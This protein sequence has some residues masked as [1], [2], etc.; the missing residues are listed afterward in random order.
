MSN[1]N[2]VHLHAP[3]KKG[4]VVFILCPCDPTDP[5]PYMAQVVVADEPIVCGLL[6][7]RCET[8]LPVVNGY[9]Q[10]PEPVDG[11]AA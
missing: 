10:K 6:C 5:I 4:D 11:D 8:Y 7:A 3:T 2:V 9:I 1:D